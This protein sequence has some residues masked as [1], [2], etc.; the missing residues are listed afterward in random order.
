MVEGGFI[1]ASDIN[2]NIL[3]LSEHCEILQSL[4]FTKKVVDA[5]ADKRHIF[6]G[7]EMCQV[8]VMAKSSL[9]IVEK[10]YFPN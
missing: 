6:I 1:I 2:F 3:I 8:L 9:I 7:I 5:V 4:P 10:I